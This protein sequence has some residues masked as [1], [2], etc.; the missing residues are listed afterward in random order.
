MSRKAIRS[1]SSLFCINSYSYVSIPFV[2]LTLFSGYSCRVWGGGS[3]QHCIMEMIGR[4]NHIVKLAVYFQ[5]HSIVARQWD[6]G[7]GLLESLH[8]SSLH[9]NRPDTQHWGW[10]CLIVPH[11]VSL[12]SI[13]ARSDQSKHNP[14]FHG[15]GSAD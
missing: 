10:M 9:A 3:G 7:G 14:V 4:R 1:G 15:S 12:C 11:C 2:I 13:A 6:G 8:P 5:N